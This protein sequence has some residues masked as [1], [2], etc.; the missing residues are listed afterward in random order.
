MP[1]TPKERV[2][3]T[4]RYM[5]HLRMSAMEAESPKEAKAMMRE[6]DALWESIKDDL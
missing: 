4:L 5:E 6:Y 2:A 3:R 1:E